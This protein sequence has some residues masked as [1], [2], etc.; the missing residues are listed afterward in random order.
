M[1][2]EFPGNERIRCGNGILTPINLNPWTERDPFHKEADFSISNLIEPSVG[3]FLTDNDSPFSSTQI[4]LIFRPTHSS[5]SSVLTGNVD[6]NEI[7]TKTSTTKKPKTSTS[8]SNNIDFFFETLTSTTKPKRKRT[9]TSASRRPITIVDNKID[10]STTS[11]TTKRPFENP[12]SKLGRNSNTTKRSTDGILRK[13]I[14]TKIDK[15][16]H[17]SDTVLELTDIDMRPKQFRNEDNATKYLDNKAVLKNNTEELES[18][19][20]HNFYS[21]ANRPN[22]FYPPY[23]PPYQSITA[24]KRPNSFE[25]N[26]P[27][28]YNRL[29]S[30]TR[31]SPISNKLSGPFSYDTPLRPMT[32]Q[33]NYDNMAIPLYVSPNRQKPQLNSN[34]Q[35]NFYRRP[36][37][38][39]PTSKKPELS[40]FLIVETT[41]RT[42][43]HYFIE[44]TTKK[45]IFQ[46]NLPSNDYFSSASNANHFLSS[47]NKF[48]SSITRKPPINDYDDNFDGYLRPENND[49]HMPF[50]NKNHQNSYYDYQK[51]NFKPETSTQGIKYYFIKNK[52][53][54][55]QFGKENDDETETDDTPTK[56]YA[57]IYD[58]P[59]KDIARD[60]F[61]TLTNVT[62]AKR[63][64]TIKDRKID[65][66][67][68]RSKSNIFAN[69]VIVPFRL[70]TKVERPDNWVNV[71]TKE[72]DKKHLPEVPAL[73]QDENLSRELPK[74][75]GKTFNDE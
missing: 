33:V 12:F 56:R 27:N 58:E 8:F 34:Y 4:P 24:T 71:D 6:F 14:S 45:S 15:L 73:N 74:P 64:L 3:L 19:V 38:S 1:P 42:T 70:L 23:Q 59:L 30:S 51:Y 47:F 72:K 53:H 68:G 52:L 61:V 75:F 40:T 5:Q 10:F 69:T 62:D 57:E 41:R 17:R 21:Y 11:K 39:Y 48:S 49:Y 43:P 63:N 25:N 35:Q 50:V 37:Y 66:I 55:Y 60:D 32:P 65:S 36:Q 16:E 20:A 26:R 28:I 9:T 67:D 46:S 22:D 54:K 2:S 18:R 13:R 31:M 7:A 29:E 44:P